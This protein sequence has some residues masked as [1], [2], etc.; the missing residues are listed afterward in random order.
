MRIK[1]VGA[2]VLLL[3][4][5]LLSP[6]WAFAESDERPIVEYFYENYCD[7]CDPAADFVEEYRALT[8][9]SM[10]QYQY[11][12]HNAVKEAGKAK[13]GEAIERYGLSADTVRLPMV[14]I[15]GKAYMGATEIQTDLPE[16]AL[17]RAETTDSTVY[18]L[19]VTAC[20]SC[21]RAKQVLDAL[22][23]RVDV[24]M[25][26]YE[27]QSELR[28]IPVDIGAETGLA[29]ALFEEFGVPEEKRLAPIILIGD[30]YYQGAESIERFL[31]YALGRGY[32][33][34]T[35]VIEGEAALPALE[36][37]GTALAGLIGGLNP[38]ALS[39]LLLF[40]SLL[41]NMNQRVG[42]MAALFLLSKFI[43]YLL[44]GTVLL[45]VFQA[46]NPS[47]LPMAIK[48]LLTVASL[49]LIA[50]NLRDA[51]MARRERYGD[52]R[53]QL[54]AGMRRGL[55]S[56]IRS[57][58]E[59]GG[60]GA[61]LIVALGAL[62]AAGEFLCSGQVYL[63]TLL[64]A[65]QKGQDTQRLLLMLIVYC[66]AFLVPSTA[67]SLLIVKG[68]SALMLS[69]FMRRRMVLIKLITALFF[70]AV[71]VVVWLL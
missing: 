57:A 35:P 69:E 25:G 67:L 18:Y 38:C 28:L 31:S 50:L 16:Y 56:R 17:S 42:R 68:K 59:G 49:V 32:G 19:Y 43:T 54:P 27:F 24:K 21:Q 13:L 58:L 71:L 20:E 65:L 41:A 45:T 26:D 62:V 1:R 46:W 37:G 36:W 33:L 8:G 52:I 3:V 12:S 22:P 53:N 44:I 48:I 11:F 29:Y 10:A 51:W 55:Q 9:E 15:D 64:T 61:L 2:W 40:L 14:I 7:S 39:M 6:F 60:V 23:E 4:A 34:Q 5:A 30:R 66:A 47:W 70:A 63:A